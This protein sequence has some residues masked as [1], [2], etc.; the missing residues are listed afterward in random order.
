[1][2]K[3]ESLVE[4]YKLGKAEGY[5]QGYQKATIEANAKHGAEIAR[6]REKLKNTFPIKVAFDQEQQINILRT[7]IEALKAEQ[8]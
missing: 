8:K 1:M 4:M 3:P 6:L 5:S 2:T 7:K